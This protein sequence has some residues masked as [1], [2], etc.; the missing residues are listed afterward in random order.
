MWHSPKIMQGMSQQPTPENPRTEPEQQYSEPAGPATELPPYSDGAKHVLWHVG[1]REHGVPFSTLADLYDLFYSEG[2]RTAAQLADK[3]KSID[4]PNELK[5]ALYDAFLSHREPK[6]VMD[7]RTRLDK[8]VDVVK[9][10]AQLHSTPAPKHGGS[11][12]SVAERHPTI[13]K[14]MAEA[15]TKESDKE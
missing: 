6:P 3:L 5:T 11:V 15:A 8:A 10:V 9:R 1:A 14:L 7:Y 2:V 4:V 12:A 13:T